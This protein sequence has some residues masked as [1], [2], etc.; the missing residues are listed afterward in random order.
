[1]PMFLN[2]QSTADEGLDWGLLGDGR[3][4]LVILP[5]GPDRALLIDIEAA[6]KA[7]WDAL[8]PEAMPVVDS[9]QFHH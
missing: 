9:F 5:L 7:A 3:M 1:M 8:L 6:D 2:A 4:R